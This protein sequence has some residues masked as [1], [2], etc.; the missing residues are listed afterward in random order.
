[1]SLEKTLERIADALEILAAKAICAHRR[2]RADP[3]QTTARIEKAAALRRSRRSRPRSR[4][5]LPVRLRN[6]SVR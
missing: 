4:R 6:R 3:K 2:A 5:R 1:M